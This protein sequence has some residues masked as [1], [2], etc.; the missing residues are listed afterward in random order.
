MYIHS[1]KPNPMILA[2]LN[3]TGGA[4]RR[5]PSMISVAVDITTPYTS[6]PLIRLLFATVPAP[7]NPRV[8]QSITLPSARMLEHPLLTSRK[9]ITVFPLTIT[10]LQEPSPGA[11]LKG[12]PSILPETEPSSQPYT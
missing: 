12:P 4:A 5:P 8:C 1:S 6:D 7:P 3:V 2:A 10:L 11:A 9:L